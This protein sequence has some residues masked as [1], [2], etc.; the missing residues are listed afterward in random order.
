[1][2]LI[3][4]DLP[5]EKYHQKTLGVA[6]KTALDKINQSPAH[7]RAW[8]DAE[9][10]QTPAMRFGSLFHLYTLELPKALA[11]IVVMPKFSGKGSVAAREEWVASH[12]DCEI[13]D[14]DDWDTIRQM[15]DAVRKHPIAAKLLDLCKPEV[16]IRW[17]DADTGIECKSRLDG[18]VESHR[19]I[20]DLKTT[21][22][23]SPIEFAR[24]AFNFRYH[25]QSSFYS[26]GTAIATGL[27]P[28]AFIFI[29]VEKAA[30]FAVATY[31]LG[32]RELELGHQEYR[33]DMK[34]LADCIERD[35]W[36]AF[37][38][39]T[40]TLTYPPYAFKGN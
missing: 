10:K 29:A 4:F 8:V 12:A 9:E 36:P 21:A 11:S 3:D 15:G 31:Q 38:T 14:Q 19:V 13:V 6:S 40:Q 35:E 17:T 23:A 37:G 18:W 22:D 33:A 25:L 26:E 5:A 20:L 2:P 7:Y 28:K 16:S 24:S 30:P 27:S 34:T 39:N 1:M 32:D